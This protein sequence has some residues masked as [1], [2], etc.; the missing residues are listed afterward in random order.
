MYFYWLSLP[1][2]SRAQIQLRNS[3]LGATSTLPLLALYQP[4]QQ[5]HRP[6]L[7]LLLHRPSLDRP[8]PLLR[9]SSRLNASQEIVVLH[10]ESVVSPS[11][12]DWKQTKMAELEKYPPQ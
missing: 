1:H 6:K 11:A 3:P 9:K 5:A 10:G 7:I 8:N 4:R 2:F 12:P